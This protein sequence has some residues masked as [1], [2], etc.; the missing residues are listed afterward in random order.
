MFDHVIWYAKYL[1]KY[2]EN[3]IENSYEVSVK[4]YH[5]NKNSYN[6]LTLVS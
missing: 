2:N 5:I 6:G 3:F 1:L 4:Y